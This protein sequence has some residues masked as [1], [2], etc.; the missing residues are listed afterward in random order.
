[1]GI[2]PFRCLDCDARFFAKTI[3]ELPE[4][5]REDKAA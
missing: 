5:I 2:R 4:L 3:P 1:M